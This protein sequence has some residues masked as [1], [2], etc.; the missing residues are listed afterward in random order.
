M[1]L[2]IM[3]LIIIGLLMTELEDGGQKSTIYD[4]HR[5]TGF[6]VLVLALFRWFWM[7]TNDKPVPLG[8]WSA[9]EVGMAH[10]TKWLLMILMLIMPVTG[11]VNTLSGG[12]DLTI[13]GQTLIA[14]LSSPDQ[15]LHNASELV[16]ESAAYLMLLVL[17]FHILAVLKHHLIRRD[18][19]LKRMLGFK[20]S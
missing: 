18:N 10:L 1:A 13:F 7:L 11:I 9:G 12:S 14:G 6:L 15:W 16:H 20:S 4:L 5:S 19:T 2:L 8:N 3:G 17:L